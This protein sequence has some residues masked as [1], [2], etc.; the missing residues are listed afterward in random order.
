VV[1]EG[2]RA[3]ASNSRQQPT[4]EE[5]RGELILFIKI[6]NTSLKYIT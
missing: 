5:N 6:R 3:T 2:W 4:V 1:E